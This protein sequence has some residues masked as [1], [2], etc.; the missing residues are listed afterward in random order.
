[1]VA[2]AALKFKTELLTDALNNAIL[3]EASLPEEVVAAVD[4]DFVPEV[5]W[6]SEEEPVVPLVETDGILGP[7]VDDETF[8]NGKVMKKR[9]NVR[10]VDD[11]E[12]VAG[13]GSSMVADVLHR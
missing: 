3:E 1:M 9:G 7:T 11:G 12:T 2:E 4:G 6:P 13:I 10:V 5:F 8:D